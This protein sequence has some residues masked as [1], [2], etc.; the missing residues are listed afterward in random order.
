MVRG[1]EHRKPKGFKSAGHAKPESLFL[2]FISSL[3]S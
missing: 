1:T 3:V 2:L